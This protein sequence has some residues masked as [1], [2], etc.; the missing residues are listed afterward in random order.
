MLKKRLLFKYGNLAKDSKAG[1]LF[2]RIFLDP[3]FKVDLLSETELI[4]YEKKNKK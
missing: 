3:N 4:S 1:N 2:A